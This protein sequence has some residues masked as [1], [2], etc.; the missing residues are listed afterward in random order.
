[1]NKYE[2]TFYDVINSIEYEC[3]NEDV[4]ND[5]LIN[6]IFANY[7]DNNLFRVHP[8]EHNGFIINKD[9]NFNN[10]ILEF[11]NE[12]KKIKI[13]HTMGN[14]RINQDLVAIPNNQNLGFNPFINQIL[15]LGFNEFLN[16]TK[17]PLQ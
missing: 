8:I 5:Y 9:L 2:F 15:K 6:I 16:K 4:L 10:A 1:M 11:L 12:K 17:Y 14:S 13:I 3:V 7:A